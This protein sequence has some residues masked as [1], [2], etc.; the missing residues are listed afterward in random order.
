MKW[1]PQGW[2]QK[3]ERLIN[4]CEDKV[5][6][7]LEEII[8]ARLREAGETVI[9]GLLEA[10]VKIGFSGIEQR[11]DFEEDKED[12]RSIPID[13]KNTS[14]VNEVRDFSKAGYAPLASEL[15][16]PKLNIET[17][18]TKASSGGLRQSRSS[19]KE[20][21]AAK[22][23]S[24]PSEAEYGVPLPLV[25]VG[26]SR[27]DEE[28]LYAFGIIQVNQESM[29]D[30]LGMEDRPCRIVENGNL[31]MLV[32]PVLQKEYSEESLH[33]YMEDMAWVESHARRHEETL[34]KTLEGRSIIPLPF[35]TIFTDEENIKRQLAQNAEEIQADLQRL[36]NHNEMHVKLFVDRK[37]LL[38]KLHEELPYSGEQSGGGYFQK[39]QW[40]KKIEE[41]MERVMNDYGESL[42]QDLNDISAEVILLD[43]AG[44]VAP[45]GQQVVFAVQYLMA[46]ESREEW[47]K[48]LKEFDEAADSLG[49]IL[50]VSGP[51]PPYH[52][53]QLIKEET[54]SG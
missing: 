10:P 17:S 4:Q 19:Q 12:P 5:I 14:Q 23:E 39:R 52:F 50:D 27:L 6:L 9:Q 42:Y 36:G 18:V 47:D 41:E 46:K 20:L 34:L 15:V 30:L 31:G 7:E 49:F 33:L 11:E 37:Q 22:E 2:E 51:W 3:V 29:G 8:M 43:K 32:C 21:L 48:K 53:S 13:V 16:Q 35:C 25:E 1:S 45:E 24:T 38:E 54:M 44:V 28:V 26:V 40:E